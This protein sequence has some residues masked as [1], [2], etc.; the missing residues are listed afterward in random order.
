MKRSATWLRTAVSSVKDDAPLAVLLLAML[1]LGIFLR[2]HHLGVPT[3]MKWDE[4]H[5]VNVARSY[6]GHHYATDDHPPFG[7]LIIAGVMALLGDSAF[8]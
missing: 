3:V 7:K 1:G 8:A 6:V 2:V 5:Y 4:H